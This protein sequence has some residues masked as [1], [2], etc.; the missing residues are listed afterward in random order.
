MSYQLALPGLD[1]SA[2]EPPDPGA[3]PP[4]PDPALDLLADLIAHGVPARQARTLV[5]HILAPVVLHQG[6]WSVPDSLTRH[7]V[8]SRHAA[9]LAGTLVEAAT[10][11][12]AVA[13][14]MTA[15]LC[16][17]LDWEWAHIYCVLAVRY[18]EQHVGAT[19]DEALRLDLGAD[20]GLNGQQEDL[21]RQ[22]RRDIARSRGKHAKK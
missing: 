17:P 20:R 16:F 2:P 11:P 6:G 5:G 13:Y 10:D 12:E 4:A 9:A 15:S 18:M 7:I 3:A 19:L 21:L 8:S 22:L 1:D 14:L